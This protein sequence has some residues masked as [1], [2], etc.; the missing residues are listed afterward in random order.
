MID[1]HCHLQF[2]AFD[3][4]RAAV[5]GRMR[6]AGVVGA[7]V[8]GCDVAS[9]RAAITLAGQHEDVYATA[10]VHPND[11]AGW[12]DATL[13][14]VRELA[15]HERVVAIGETGLDYYRDRT[16]PAQQR[17][18]FEAQAELALDLGLPLVVHDREAHEDVMRVLEHYAGRGLR[19][20]WHCFSGDATLAL[21][22]TDANI[23]VSFAGPIS[24]PKNAELRAAAAAVPADH[25]TIE[26]DAPFL[27]PQP[28]RGK[29]NEPAHVAYVADTIAE[30]RGIPVAQVHRQSTLTARRLFGLPAG[31]GNPT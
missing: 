23:V 30:A 28:R 10:G 16:T 13:A 29:R 8:V 1:T 12:S 6:A 4:D 21:R 5:L 9:S 18:A 14:C 17:Q 11:C 7:V 26:T 3:E 20:V 15:G 27:S 25:Y 19:A 24:Y 22:A 2:D 31:E